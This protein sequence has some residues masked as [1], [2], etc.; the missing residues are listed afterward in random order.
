MAKSSTFYGLRRGSTK[1]HTYSVVDGQQITKDRVEGCKNPRTLAQMSQRCM[2]ATIGSAYS[3][4]KSICDHSFEGLTPGMQCMREF[5]SSNLKQLRICKEYDNGFFGFNKY[6]DP[7]L[8][9]GSYIVSKGSLPEPL[10]DAEISSIT[11]ADR[12]VSLTLTITSG[13]TI[14]EVA[15]AMRCKNFGD[16]CTVALMYPK[17]DGH[18]GFG[19]VRFTYK[20]GATVLDSFDVA[21][22]GDVVSATPSFTAKT[23]KL[24]VRMSN[25]LPTNATVDN[26]YFVAIASRKVNGSWQYST[27]QFDVTEATPTFA[28]AIATYP[29]G[30][31]RFLNGSDAGTAGSASS[32]NSDSGGDDDDAP[33]SGGGNG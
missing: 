30:Q 26:T 7:G 22:I 10:D 20:S 13:G 5:N 15:D 17:T 9:A 33:G 23:L 4:M 24:E 3:A 32:A 18:Y 31:E 11:V 29:V 21:T 12:K 14:A 27:A 2:V 1:S 25:V 19:A 16:M 6:Q 8:Q 28:Q